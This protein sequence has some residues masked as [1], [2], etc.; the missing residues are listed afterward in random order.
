MLELENELNILL[1]EN[2]HIKY[3]IK[4]LNISFETKLRFNSYVTN[5]YYSDVLNLLIQ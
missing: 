2:S 3:N 4:L 5:F 1:L